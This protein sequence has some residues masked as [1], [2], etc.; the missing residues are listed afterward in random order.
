MIDSNLTTVENLELK[1]SLTQFNPYDMGRKANW[2]QV[3]GTDSSLWLVP[4]QKGEL[5]GD[6][7]SWFKNEQFK[8]SKTIA[9]G[10]KKGFDKFEDEEDVDTEIGS[11]RGGALSKSKTMKAGPKKE[12]VVLKVEEN[13]GG[14]FNFDDYNKNFSSQNTP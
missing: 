14:K 6:G 7:I 1:N 9:P 5:L 11:Q 8:K 10:G 13:K 12:E 3:M 2:E 4:L